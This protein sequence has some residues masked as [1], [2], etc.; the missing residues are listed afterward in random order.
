MSVPG[1]QPGHYKLGE[2]VGHLCADLNAPA[3]IAGMTKSK[4]TI[5]AEYRMRNREALNSRRREI[6][7][8]R[9]VKLSPFTPRYKAPPDISILSMA[10]VD[11]IH[12]FR[13]ER[14]SLDEIGKRVGKKRRSTSNVVKRLYCR[15]WLNVFQVYRPG[16]KGV[17]LVYE[18]SEACPL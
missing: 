16:E 7:A 6:R 1:M 4:A 9:A 15:G 11:A 5:N 12:V 10:E 13:G 18:L 3:H 2:V 14:L 17:H 8:G